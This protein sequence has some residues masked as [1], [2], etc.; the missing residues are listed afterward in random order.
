[1]ERRPPGARDIVG[2]AAEDTEFGETH[3]EPEPEARCFRCGTV[4]VL[5]LVTCAVFA[6]AC[7]SIVWPG[8]AGTARGS[9]HGRTVPAVRWPGS[10]TSARMLF[11]SPEVHEVVAENVLR[12]SRGAL[13]TADLDMVI[14]TVAEGLHN[15]SRRLAREAPIAARALDARLLDRKELAAVLQALRLVGDPRVQ[16]IGLDVARAVRESAADGP[17]A[18]RRS[19][20]L[21]LQPRLEALRQLREELA[22]VGDPTLADGAFRWGLMLEPD[23]LR[24]LATVQGEWERCLVPE[25]TGELPRRLSVMHVGLGVVPRGS[26]SAASAHAEE[27]LAGVREGTREE[28]RVLLGLARALLPAHAAKIE[29]EAVA[30]PHVV[31]CELDMAPSRDVGFV[32]ALACP[33]R[34]GSAGVE[35]LRC[36]GLEFE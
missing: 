3:R 7:S 5:V 36:V 26:P 19:V 30:T 8:R 4:N 32:Q 12:A 1:M 25:G 2:F 24:A 27:K 21:R 18:V 20:E 35:A 9:V 6:L 11:D 10:P 13:G 14:A 29:V 33:L 16:H 17:E 23:N 22:S 31:S 34:L 15:V 28:A